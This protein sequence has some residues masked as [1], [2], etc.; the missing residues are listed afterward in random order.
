MDFIWNHWSDIIAIYGALHVIARVITAATATPKDD[1][2]VA[3]MDAVFSAIF[4]MKR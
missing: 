2:W 4:G 1:E 3:K